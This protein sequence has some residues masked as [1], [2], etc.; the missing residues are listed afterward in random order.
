[1]AYSVVELCMGAGGQAI[2]LEQAGLTHVFGMDIDR[3]ACATVRHNRP[4][5]DVR[6]GDIRHLN[7]RD[8]RGIDVLAGGIPCPPF[9]I[10]GHQKGAED[11]RD[12][13]PT[14]LRLVRE[15]LPSVVLIE[16][17]P[18][19]A[20]SRFN[21]YRDGIFDQFRLLGYEL[22]THIFNAADFGVPQ[23][24]PR[25]VMVGVK[26]SL[27][28]SVVWPELYK[29]RMTVGDALYP[30]MAECGWA[31]ALSWRDGAQGIA[32][33]LVGGS[34]K[35]GGADLGPTRARAKW[36]NLGV[37]GRGVA[38]T[39]PDTHT[40]LDYVPRLTNRMAAR[41][42]GFPEDW[43]FIG[44]KTSVYRQIGNAFP[45][46]V[47]TAIGQAIVNALAKGRKRKAQI[48]LDIAE[49]TPA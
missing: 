49:K 8:L 26:T 16:N 9:S 12:L 31:G 11:E 34:K 5:W 6:Q 4:S 15:S 24:R 3:D 13:F 2:G 1:M 38:D 25:F 39:P 19:F 32:P 45:P 27:R 22:H 7:G 41:V 42:Q 46:P 18:G 30:F 23:L 36:A 43:A 47:A 40:P 28:R 33:T 10:A 20:S 37:D 44:K 48:L 29:T 35:H 14:V 21:T 17:V